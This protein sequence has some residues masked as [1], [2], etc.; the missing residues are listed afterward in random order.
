MQDNK[1]LGT[2]L[3]HHQ[4]LYVEGFLFILSPAANI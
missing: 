3:Q 2:G 1:S 4:R